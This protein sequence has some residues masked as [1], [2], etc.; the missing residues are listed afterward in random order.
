MA[1]ANKLPPANRLPPPPAFPESELRAS[2]VDYPGARRALKAI[3][4]GTLS[5]DIDHRGGFECLDEKSLLTAVPG[6]RI[7]ELPGANHYVF[8]RM[9]QRSWERLLSLS[10][11][12][13]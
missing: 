5:S 9:R 10:Q 8:C 7:V 4:E 2:T 13:P 3:G 6:A 12:F 1:L 11:V